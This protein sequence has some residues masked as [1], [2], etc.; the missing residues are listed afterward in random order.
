MK[1]FFIPYCFI[2][3]NFFKSSTPEQD[4]S[5]TLQEVTVKAYEQN[6]KL[7]QVPA[8]VAVINK[9]QLSHFNNTNILPAL[10]Y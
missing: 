8:S 2:T 3:N 4:S 6:R 10:K 1:H 7:M 9:T 5:Q